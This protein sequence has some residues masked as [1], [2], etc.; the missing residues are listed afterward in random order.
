[1]KSGATVGVLSFVV[2]SALMAV[3]AAEDGIPSKSKLSQL[4]LSS[5]EVVEDREGMQ[6]RGS[7]IAVVG[8]QYYASTAAPGFGLFGFPGFGFPFANVG[9]AAVFQ[10]AT[11]I[12]GEAP[13][14]VGDAAAA[15][16]TLDVATQQPGPIVVETNITANG[17]SGLTRTTVS[18]GVFAVSGINLFGP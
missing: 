1:M 18:G 5:M 4:G 7:A 13:N 11:A 15:V 12:D 2:F 6:V 8:G 17:F 10:H 14:F 9:G 16:G 3:G